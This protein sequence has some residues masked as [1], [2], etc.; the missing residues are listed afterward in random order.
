MRLIRKLFLAIILPLMAYNFIASADG[1]KAVVN[2]D[3]ITS[4]EI[5]QR[6]N[7][8]LLISRGQAAQN[9]M[10][11][12]ND[13]ILQGLIDEKLKMQAA[14]SVGQTV[15][16]AEVQRA[17]TSIEENNKMP[18]GTL[19][20]ILGEQGID[21]EQFKNQ[22]RGQ[23]AW[24]NYVRAAIV[25]LI[26]ESPV[27]VDRILQKQLK[28]DGSVTEYLVGEIFIPVRSTGLENDAKETADRVRSLVVGQY[29]FG[30]IARNFSEAP[31]RTEDG[32]LGWV[33]KGQLEPAR[34]NAITNLKVG[35]TSQPI[36]TADGYY[37]YRLLNKRSISTTDNSDLNG[38]RER[39]T[40]Q[41]R[42]EDIAR[43]AA[44][45]G[46][47]LRQQAFLEIR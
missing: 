13:D 46:Q 45:V 40:T 35:G 7:L 3:V 20:K 14:R 25:P 38:L 10:T 36:R 2:D 33:V 29:R 1:I 47:Q 43:E 30:E 42:S 23:L 17:V 34:D 37:I 11:K 18:A 28:D 8:A 39:I 21:I 4:S 19:A 15:D 41:L 16:E 44:Y 5:E 26:Q 31:S 27:D 22:I 12:L 9:G 24:R 32:I 6:V